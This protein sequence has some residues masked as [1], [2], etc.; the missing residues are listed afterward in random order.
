MCGCAGF[1]SCFGDHGVRETPGPIP[2]P[3]VKPH[4]AD[5]TARGTVWETRTSPGYYFKAG[6]SIPLWVEEPALKHVDVQSQATHHGPTVSEVG[7][8]RS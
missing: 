5:G 6:S 7:W 1:D 3:E 2:N 8:A 4:S